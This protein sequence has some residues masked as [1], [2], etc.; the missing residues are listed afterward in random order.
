MPVFHVNAQKSSKRPFVS[1][2]NRL[3]WD[4]ENKGTATVLYL[5]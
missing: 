5:P 1:K 2:E 3:K 4:N